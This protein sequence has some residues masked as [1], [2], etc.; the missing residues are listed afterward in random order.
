MDTSYIKF[1]HFTKIEKYCHLQSH[2]AAQD[3]FHPIYEKRE[4]PQKDFTIFDSHYS[5]FQIEKITELSFIDD[6]VIPGI[7]KIYMRYFEDFRRGVVEKSLFTEE[8]LNGFSKHYYNNINEAT[9]LIKKANYL[10]SKIKATLLLNL[11]SLN[12]LIDEFIENPNNH[13]DSKIKFNWSRTDI[14]YFF[15]LLRLNKSIEPIGNADLGRIIDTCFEYYSKEKKTYLNI[16][17]SRKHLSD[18]KRTQRSEIETNNNLRELLQHDD[19]YS[20]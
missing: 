6:Y 20:H 3:F 11:G 12:D 10:S 19:F 16:N 1:E 14:I 15:H 9:Q 8:L 18:F 5:D 17:L 7:D 4:E 2:F 13:I